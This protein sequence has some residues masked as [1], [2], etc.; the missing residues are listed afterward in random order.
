M[1]YHIT[2]RKRDGSTEVGRVGAESRSQALSMAAIQYS[3]PRSNVVSAVACP[4]PRVTRCRNCGG[5]DGCYP[6]CTDHD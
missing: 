5:V 2:Y 3:V 1:L 4:K 6:G